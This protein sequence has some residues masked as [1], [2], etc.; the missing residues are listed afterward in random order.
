MR[1]L[2]TAG[3]TR[4]PID[5]VRYISNYSSGQLGLAL[6]NAILAAGHQVIA[7]LGPVSFQLP[8][9]ARRLDVQTTRQMHD[10]VLQHWPD[11]DI[12]IMAAAVAD[13]RPKQVSAEKLGRL[14]G[15]TIELEPTEDIIAAAAFHRLPHQRVIGFSLEHSGNLARARE[16]LARKRIDMIVFNPL[17]T[18][19]SVDIQA[20][21]LYADGREELLPQMPKPQFAQTLVARALSLGAGSANPHP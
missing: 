14:S 5:P 18:M 13:Y 1:F 10:A 21:L 7:I 12:L 6:A 9:E 8:A 16:K 11:H 17:E 15:M 4:E 19:N 3:P 20:A 2:I